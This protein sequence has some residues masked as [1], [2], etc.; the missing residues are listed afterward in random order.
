M[1]WRW[2]AVWLCA[3]H[4]WTALVLL[5]WLCLLPIS[6]TLCAGAPAMTRC[7]LHAV[8]SAS[9][10]NT[11]AMTCCPLHAAPSPWCADTRSELLPPP[12]IVCAQIKL[13]RN[14][15]AMQ[16]PRFLP[17]HQC[18]RSHSWSQAEPSRRQ[19]CSHSPH[20]DNPPSRHEGQTRDVSW[21]TKR[22]KPKVFQSG[23]GSCGGVCA[24]C[25]GCHKHFFSKCEVTR[26]W[27]G[28]AAAA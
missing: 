19:H 8:S 24:V 15:R 17:G 25:L 9:R 11:P 2:P 27:N 28:S 7:L 4:R 20:I 14:V 3:S 23:A 6:S 1:L 26:L 21:Q 13:C 10:G 12:C 5:L 16:E 18:P 22:D